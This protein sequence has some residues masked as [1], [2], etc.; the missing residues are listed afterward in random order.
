M[1]PK[2]NS[3]TYAISKRRKTGL[4]I[5][6]LLGA[7]SLAWLDHSSLLSGR[8]RTPKS[9]ERARAHDLQR[10]NGKVFSVV[11][12]IDG[13][14][15]DI[16]TA[17]GQYKS[18]RIRLLGVDSPETPSGQ[19]AAMYFGPQAAEFTRALALAKPVTV[20][21]DAPNPTRGKYGRLLAYVQLPDGRFLNEVLLSEGFAYADLRFRHS[22]YNRYKQLEAGARSGRKGLW[23][24]VTR[25]QLPEWLR[26]REPGLLN[27]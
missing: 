11:T 12:V 15:I 24:D 3:A 20:Y 14:T 1:R 4:I 26:Q 9:D 25:G 10:Y 8:N 13:D 17:D 27:R 23:Q 22:F 2:Q 7:V 16:D 5:L 18:T 21:L 19:M 6:C